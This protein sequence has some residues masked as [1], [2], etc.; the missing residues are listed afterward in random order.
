MGKR[1]RE[2][3]CDYFFVTTNNRS[4]LPR[5][6]HFR[7]TSLLVTS[8]TFSFICPEQ[9]QLNCS[10]ATRKNNIEHVNIVLLATS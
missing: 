8:D 6:L 7:G 10:Q 4:V 2:F 9:S 5:V 1:T 3:S